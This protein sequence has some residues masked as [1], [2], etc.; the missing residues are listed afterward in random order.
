MSTYLDYNASAPIDQRVLDVMIEVYKGTIGNADSRTCL[1]YTSAVNSVGIMPDAVQDGFARGLS[2][3]LS[4]SYHP[5]GSYW[6]QK[7][8]DDLFR[9]L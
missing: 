7:I 5:E 8:V 1:L 2:S 3:P 9:L 4:W 6:E